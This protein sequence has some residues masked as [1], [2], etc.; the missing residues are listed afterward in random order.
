MIHSF[1]DYPQL[2]KATGA[3]M[4]QRIETLDACRIGLSTG[5][6]PTAAYAYIAQQLAQKPFLIPKIQG[7]Q[8]D[9][10]YGLAADHPG[11]CR[12]YLSR[13]VLEPWALP[14]DQCFLLDGRD[15]DQE[16][17]ILAMKKSLQQRPMDLCILG[18]GKNGHLALN[19]PG[20]T[21]DAPCR[22]VELAASSK[23]HPM[24]T[25][26]K[27]PVQ[28][29]ITIGLKEILESKEIIL[30]IT[31]EGKKDAYQKLQD[32]AAVE[33]FPASALYYHDNWTCFVDEAA[34]A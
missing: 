24:L 15:P 16:G 30:I 8:I 23:T 9:E 6:S 2:S 21:L 3:L 29:G 7:F 26:A 4:V 17:Q 19:E 20:S 28:K 10:W 1:P 22:I 18:L 33:D 5:F 27:V 25:D 32:K 11:S 13:H 12:H 31:G 14:A 34:V